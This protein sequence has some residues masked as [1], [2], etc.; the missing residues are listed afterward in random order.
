MQTLNGQQIWTVQSSLYHHKLWA[1]IRSKALAHDR[2][3]LSS[4]STF[5]KDTPQLTPQP[6]LDLVEVVVL[7]ELLRGQAH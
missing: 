5:L 6:L 3:Q 1:Y 2:A 4:E 7:G